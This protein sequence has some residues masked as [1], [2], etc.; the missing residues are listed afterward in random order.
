[1]AK[2]KKPLLMIVAVLLI[3][4]CV[5]R[6]LPISFSK[7]LHHGAEPDILTGFIAT[8]VIHTIENGSLQAETYEI[9]MD[10][11]P[12]IYTILDS[13]D[14]RRDLRNLIPRILNGITVYGSDKY[15]NVIL[16]S[17]GQS[18]NIEFVSK[19]KVFIVFGDGSTRLYHPTDRT[20]LD[21]LAEFIKTNGEKK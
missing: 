4:L 21:K 15:V 8:T 1:M 3:V 12:E 18:R 5:W 9:G 16:Q 7:A 2:K 14:Y 6:F 19:D 17:A 13:S 20:V 11:W 10:A